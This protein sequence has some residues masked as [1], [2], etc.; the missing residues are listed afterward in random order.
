MT[1]TYISSKATIDARPRSERLRGILGQQAVQST[2]SVGGAFASLHTHPNKKDIDAL[3]IDDNGYGYVT[4][5]SVLQGETEGEW[6][7]NITTGKIKSG[8]ADSAYDLAHDSPFIK[9]LMSLIVPVDN[10]GN[11]IEYAQYEQAVALKAKLNL[12]SVG[13]ISALGPNGNTG[14]GGSGISYDRL[15]S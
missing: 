15:D 9:A 8:Y 10:N 14:I 5:S 11:E 13:D 2:G 1:K 7:E 6:V 4:L 12:F 3:S